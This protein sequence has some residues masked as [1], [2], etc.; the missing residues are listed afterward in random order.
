[1]SLLSFISL[2]ALFVLGFYFRP[3]C[4]GV[5][6]RFLRQ[7]APVMVPDGESSREQYQR[8]KE[9]LALEPVLPPLNSTPEEIERFGQLSPTVQ[10]Q[11]IQAR[12]Q[13]GLDG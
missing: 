6:K 8:Y 3:L 5:R 2:V 7:T 4:S 9:K 1:M 10:R 13:I 12:K 11:V